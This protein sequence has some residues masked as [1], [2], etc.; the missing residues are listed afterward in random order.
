M[1]RVITGTVIEWPFFKYICDLEGLVPEVD[2]F[3]QF[4]LDYKGTSIVILYSIFIMF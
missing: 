1:N 3:N 2:T 4:H